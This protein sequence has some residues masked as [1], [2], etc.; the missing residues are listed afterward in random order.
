[1]LKH[2]E[3][4]KFKDRSKKHMPH[5]L[6]SFEFWGR[7]VGRI[8]GQIKSKWGEA[9]WYANL[10]KPNSLYDLIYVD[11]HRSDYKWDPSISTANAVL[12][13]INNLSKFF[14]VLFYVF[15]LYK[16]FFYNVAYWIAIAKNKD[17]ASDIVWSASYP[18]KIIFGKKIADIVHE[19][20]KL[21]D[22]ND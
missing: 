17:C 1:M 10:D 7:K 2:D 13:F 16:V 20:N 11:E 15:I 9:C 3:Y 21:A 18:N 12:D 19:K 8:D 6:S 4:V 22:L 14:G 5:T